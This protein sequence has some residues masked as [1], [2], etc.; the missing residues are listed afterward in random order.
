MSV[1]KIWFITGAS[2]GFGRTMTEFALEKGANVI[3]TLRKPEVLAELCAQF[4]TTRLLVLKLDVKESGQIAAAFA[5]AQET[6]GRIDVVFNNAGYVAVSEVES[7]KAHE[8]VVRD[9]F[10]VNFWGATR[11]SQAA[12][13]FFREVNDPVGGRLLQI[14]SLAGVKGLPSVAFYCASKHALEG[15]TEA[16]VKELDPDWNI[17][18]TLIQPGPFRTSVRSNFSIIPADPAYTHP[19]A[20]AGRAWATTITEYE[21]ADDPLKAVRRFYELVDLPEP[22]LRFPIGKFVVESLQEKA[23]SLLADANTYKSWSDGLGFAA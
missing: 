14:S 4:D 1:P 23:Q 22:P 20:A 17:K 16:L 18:I 15:V 8:E 19:A 2:S 10:D 11:I 7:A 9:M 13:K 6:F 3:A 5:K 21:D 12:V